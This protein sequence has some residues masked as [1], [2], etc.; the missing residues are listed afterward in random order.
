[1]YEAFFGLRE[2]PFELTSNSRFLLLTRTHLEALSHLEYAAA[3]MRGVTLLIG[4]AGTGKTTLLPKAFGASE[5]CRTCPP[6][7]CALIDHPAMR[8]VALSEPPSAPY[9]LGREAPPA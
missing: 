2:R 8:R 9:W 6:N 3:A 7:A 4:E 1:M 5:P